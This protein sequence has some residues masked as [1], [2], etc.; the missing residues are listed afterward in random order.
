[1]ERILLYFVGRCRLWIDSKA[2]GI[3]RN[4]AE[5]MTD[6]VF[7]IW[8]DFGLFGVEQLQMN[9]AERGKE[10]FYGQQQLIL[11]M[12]YCREWIFVI[13]SIANGTKNGVLY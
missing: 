10:T 11:V 1:M 12:E 4:T 13:V 5:A 2:M 3:S 8:S 7:M 9:H 6:C